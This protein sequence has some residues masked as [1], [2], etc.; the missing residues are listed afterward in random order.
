MDL[1]HL[2]TEVT[3]TLNRGYLLYEAIGGPSTYHVVV[4]PLVAEQWAGEIQRIPGVKFIDW[5]LR[6]WFGED[7]DVVYVGRPGRPPAPRFSTDV[8]KSLWSGATVTYV[9]LQLA[10]YLGFH[11]VVLIGVDHRFQAQGSPH[12]EVVATGEDVNHFAPNYFGTGSRWNLPDLE[13]SELAYIL[14]R[15]YYR[16]D[17]REILDATVGGALQVFPKVDYLSLFR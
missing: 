10:Y 9:A 15:H 11:Q 17:G 3:F 6:H 2:A 4:N 16:L 14:A 7:P 5:G 1:R 8:T 12:Q 13:T